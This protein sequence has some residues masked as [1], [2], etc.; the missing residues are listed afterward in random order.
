MSISSKIQFLHIQQGLEICSLK[1]YGP[2]RYTI[3]NWS[4]KFSRYSNF[5]LRPCRYADFRGFS[6]NNT[7]LDSLE[8]FLV[9]TIFMMLGFWGTLIFFGTKNFATRGLTLHTY[10]SVDTYL[11]LDFLENKSS[12]S[13]KCSSQEKDRHWYNL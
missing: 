3:F 11:D 8:L 5:E 9:F 10:L 1:E 7:Y 12:C 4:L 6:V 13:L 2:Y